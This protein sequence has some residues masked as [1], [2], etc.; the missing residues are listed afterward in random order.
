VR[1]KSSKLC[2]RR[3]NEKSL[4]IT[5]LDHKVMNIQPD[6]AVFSSV[7]K[8]FLNSVYDTEISVGFVSGEET[9][10]VGLVHDIVQN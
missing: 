5:G 6:G 4:R 7:V 1:R 10:A 2:Q 3:R 8:H 9:C